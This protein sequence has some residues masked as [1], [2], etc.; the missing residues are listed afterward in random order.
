MGFKLQRRVARINFG[1]EKLAGAE[2]T[3]RLNVSLGD[4]L[5]MQELEESKET[6]DRIAMLAMFSEKVLISW[7]LETP[8]GESIAAQPDGMTR[9]PAEESDLIISAWVKTLG[10]IPGPLGVRSP[11][12]V[13]SREE[14]MSAAT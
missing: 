3:V 9:I 8:E 1:D 10:E 14:R 12:G 13:M 4:L 5:A 6:K 7:N 11:D 2:V